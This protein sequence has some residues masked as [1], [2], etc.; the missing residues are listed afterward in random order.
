VSEN[1]VV[2]AMLTYGVLVFLWFVSA[3]EAALG[4]G[5]GW[6][7]LGLSL[8]D[9]FYGFA[10]GVIDSRDVVFF[11]AFAALWLFLA[12]RALGARTWRGL[13]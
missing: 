10:Q 11:L 1:Q 2:S 4:E 3:N 12:L 7:V 13:A 9:R 5:L 6:I 8:F